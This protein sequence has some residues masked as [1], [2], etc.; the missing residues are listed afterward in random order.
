MIPIKWISEQYARK[1]KK[2][3]TCRP[4]YQP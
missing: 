2:L 1:M 4:N 3:G